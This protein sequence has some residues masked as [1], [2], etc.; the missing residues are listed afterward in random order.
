MAFILPFLIPLFF[1]GSVDALFLAVL[2]ISVL[3]GSLLPDT[4]CGGKATIYYRF[5]AIDQFM[6]K[7]VGKSIIFL[8]SHLI[9][10]KRI[11]TEHDVK[12]EHR[13]IMH[14]PIGVLFSSLMLVI[15]LIIFGI[16]FSLLNWSVLL[17]IFLG[18]IIGQLLHLFEDSCTISGINWLFPFKTKELRGKI[19]TFSRDPERMD[20]R[21]MAY[22]GVLYLLSL[23]L[24]VGYGFNIISEINIWLLLVG[25]LICEVLILVFIILSSQ[26]NS[27]AWMVKKGT[28]KQVNKYSRRLKKNMGGI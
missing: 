15:P 28:I 3:I 2:I 4:D 12:D 18:L 13:G 20:I 16:V 1:L 9:S 7:V 19:Y 21:P 8:F 25:V 22:A 10:S 26:S 5:P 24:V 14:S 11:K 17:I 6:K 27:S 23:L